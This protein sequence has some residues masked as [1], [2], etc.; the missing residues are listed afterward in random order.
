MTKIE[1]SRNTYGGPTLADMIRDITADERLSPRKRQDVCSAL[2]SIAK[3]VA[4][5]ESGAQQAGITEAKPEKVPADAGWIR[6][7]LK[8]F[9]PAMA[10]FKPDRWANVQSLVRFAFAHLNIN[11]AR[12]AQMMSPECDDLLNGLPKEA[13]ATRISLTSFFRFCTVKGVPPDAVTQATFD[14]FGE[15]LNA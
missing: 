15:W 12:C 14:A 4:Q 13:K 3:A 6:Q 9:G 1:V 8:G 5:M 7:R 2:R 10:G 11:G